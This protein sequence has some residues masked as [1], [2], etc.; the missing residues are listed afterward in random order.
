[1]TSTAVSSRSEHRSFCRICAALCGIVVTVDGDQVVQVRGDPEHP[2]S[3]GYTCPKGRALGA[4]HH[5]PD[6]LDHPQVRRDGVLTRVSWDECLD[7]LAGRVASVVEESGP[8]AVGMFLATATSFDGPGGR[9]AHGL[10]SGLGSR[11]RYTALTIDTPCRPLVYDLMAGFPGLLPALDHDLTTLTVLVGTNPVVSHGHSHGMPDPVQRLRA[12]SAGDKE[13]WVLDPRRTE[14]A[15][16]AT[17]HL[18]VRPGGDHAVLAHVLAELLGPGGGA[19]AAYLAEHADGVDELRRAVAPFTRAHAAAVSGLS[20]EQL[21][22]L[23]AAVRRHGR[24]VVQ[25]GTGSTMSAE[26][27]ITEWLAVALQV[28]THSYEQPG[29]AW[30]H[31]GFLKCLDRRTI[32]PSG[33]EPDPVPGPA[34][35]PD[36]A[37]RYGELPCA[38]LVDEIEA[39]N[40]RALFVVGG[41]PATSLPEPARLM[42][43]L[44]RLDVL[45]VADV[46]AT[47]TVAAATHVLPCAGQ[48]ERADVPDYVDQYMLVVAS[49][50]TAAVVAPGAERR[51]LWWSM[52]ALGQRLGIATLPSGIQLETCTDDDLL[53]AYSR[54]AR[55]PLEELRATDGVLVDE[56]PVR[57]WVEQGVLP[58]GR[59][60]LAPTVLVAQLTSLTS[61]T[62][63][64]SLV[65]GPPLPAAA[66]LEMIPRRQLRTMNS[67][68]RDAAAPGGRTERGAVQLHPDDAGRL[69]IADGSAVLVASASGE[70]AGTAVLDDSLRPGV[71]SVPHGWTDPHVG[72]LTSATRGV[73]P[74][75]GMVLQSGVPVTVRPA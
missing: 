34:S 48:L 49:Q 42:A 50:H 19:D 41:N 63:H 17:R 47:E 44:G 67:Q 12:L 26:A 15:A 75:T 23:V 59:W 6:R 25:T 74:L 36:L 18:A 3:R 28:V 13:V 32:R 68:L 2:F 39:G 64:A 22:D 60:R 55:R 51:P 24:L 5:H 54:R 40:L 29:G 52:A 11:S 70:T 65:E 35:R 69:G 58:E 1:M 53:A 27:N 10:L 14:T 62:S 31:P 16:L 46:V 38:G 20:R 73:D 43:A 30:F 8:D 37:G 33:P 71:V 56:G 7:D 61:L 66:T 72:A 45:A 9:V 57:G 4:W 21:A